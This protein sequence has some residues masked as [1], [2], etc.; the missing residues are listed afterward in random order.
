MKTIKF[1]F[2]ICFL[3]I[4]FTVSTFGQTT[5]STEKVK[6]NTWSATVSAGSM[7]FY[8]DLRQFDFYPVTIQNSKDWYKLQTGLSEY[9]RG[10]SLAISK[11]LSPVFGVQGM[12]LKGALGGIR[13]SVDAHFNASLLSYG[14]NLKINF[15]P[16]FNPNIKPKKISVYGIIGIGLVDFKSREWSLSTGDTLMSYG[17]GDFGAEKKATTE[18][19]VPLGLGIKYQINNRFDI[20]L[21]SILNNVNTDKLDARVVS[22][23]AKDKYGYTCVTLTYKI[24]NNEKSL[25]WSTPKSME[26]DDLAP[27]FAGLTKKIDSLGNKLKEVD[28]KVLQLQS[29]VTALKN[30]PV[31]ADDDADGVP[32]SKDLE[33]NTPKGNMVNFQGITIP[34]GGSTSTTI[35]GT[36]PIF[37]IFFAVNSAEIDALNDEKV[38]SAAVMMKQDPN[39]KFELVGHADKTGGQAYNE[40]LSKK[41]AQ[42]VFDA[43][44]KSYG[45]EASRLTVNGVGVN[46]PLSTDVLSVNRRVDFII[47]K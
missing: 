40:I 41:R 5:P 11:Q 4:A 3:V 45:I 7:V 10:F 37:S 19:V 24:G 42:A 12:L 15:L 34:K 8:G 13:P 22:G 18:T 30:P 23:S 39:L 28:G 16:L 29:D 35:E 27:M 47:Q 1:T 43:L 32:N 2:A 38:A 33:P 21:E 17:Y 31:E 36:K 25:E 6:Y 9:D 20:G 44:T 26:S 14:F 46:D